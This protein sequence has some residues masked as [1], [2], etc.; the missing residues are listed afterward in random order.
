MTENE[1]TEVK[2]VCGKC[3]NE[4]DFSVWKHHTVETP[5]PQPGL[6]TLTYP[7]MRCNECW[8]KEHPN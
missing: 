5:F 6:P 3:R 2:P 1:I 7:S 8:E 4:I